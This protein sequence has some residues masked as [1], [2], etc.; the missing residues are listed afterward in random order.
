[1]KE[2]WLACDKE[3]YPYGSLVQFLLATGQ[4]RDEAATMLWNDI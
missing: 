1:V 3:G 4:R 2:I